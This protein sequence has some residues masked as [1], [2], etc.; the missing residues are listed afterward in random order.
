MA[1]DKRI[2]GIAG[3]ESHGMTRTQA[4]ELIAK[5][6]TDAKH[7]RLSL[8]KGRKVPL[9]FDAAA[10]R[11]LECLL[12]EGDKELKARKHRLEDRLLPFCGRLGPS[13]PLSIDR[14]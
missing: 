13:N 14:R 2:H 12:E 1:D 10:T 8:P 9:E 5:V 4:E 6:R 7:N 11:Y 3:R